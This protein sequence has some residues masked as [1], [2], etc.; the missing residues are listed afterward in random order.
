M[1]YVIGR[2][3]SAVLSLCETLGHTTLFCLLVVKAFF[4]PIRIQECIRQL[5]LMGVESLSIVVLSGS[6]TGLALALQSY[7]ALHQ[8]GVEYFVSLVISKGMIRELSPVLTGLMITGRCGSA[9]AA[10]IATMQITEQIDA[11]KTLCIN[12][13]RY[14]VVPRIVAATVAVP[15][16][17]LFSMICGIGAGYL[18]S[19]FVLNINAEQYVAIMHT[20]IEVA[21]LVGGLL[22]ALFFGLIIGLVGTYKGY[23]ASGGARGVG[24]ATTQSVVAASICIMVANYYLSLL[25]FQAGM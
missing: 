24:K 9:I 11:L 23:Y 7:S 16:A 2:L 14:L 8:L 18:L 4:Q 15:L 6:C 19:I 10:E 1:V 20:H 12:P 17:S 5:Y 22:K 3:G 25:L 21:D 13:F